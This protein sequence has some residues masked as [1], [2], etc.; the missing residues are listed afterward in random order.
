MGVDLPDIEA[1]PENHVAP[2]SRMSTEVRLCFQLTPLSL[3]KHNTTG[4][5]AVI[6]LPDSEPGV[7]EPLLVTIAMECE[8]NP[9]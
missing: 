6:S 2:L 3:A 8:D 1:F 7:F 5:I 4:P 9:R